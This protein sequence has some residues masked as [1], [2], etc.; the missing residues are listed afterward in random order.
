MNL[1]FVG[2]I[3]LDIVCGYLGALC[4]WAY[5]SIKAGI[6]DEAA[7]TLREIVAENKRRKRDSYNH[8][9]KSNAFVGFVVIMAIVVVIIL[10]E[11]KLR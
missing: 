7:P 8:A 10:I 1:D 3:L 2:T 4:K 9:K 5:Y 6:V 11:T